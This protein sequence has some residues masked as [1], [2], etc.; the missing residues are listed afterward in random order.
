VNVIGLCFAV[1]AAVMGFSAGG[2]EE[3][4][5]PGFRL[6]MSRRSLLLAATACT[7]VALSVSAVGIVRDARRVEQAVGSSPPRTL[8]GQY[9]PIRAAECR[10][11]ESYLWGNWDPLRHVWAYALSPGGGAPY[12]FTRHRYAPVWYRVERIQPHPFEGLVLSDEDALSPASCVRRNRER[13][14]GALTWPGYDGVILA[15]SPDAIRAALSS[16]DVTSKERL[17]PGIWRLAPENRAI[18]DF[19]NPAAYH[20]ERGGFGLEE[21]R[22]GR[23]VAWSAGSA[24]WLDLD[25]AADP[26]S[27]YRLRLIA[28][29]VETALPQVVR[30]EINGK[31]VAELV[32]AT[33]AW[34]DDKV[35]IPAG[36]LRAGRNRF[37]FAYARL[38]GAADSRASPSGEGATAMLFDRLEVAQ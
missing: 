12:L 29:P 8:S 28:R 34:R 5:R 24:S 27:A 18:V 26:A 23:A 35:A 10:D 3:T 37:R 25:L 7:T 33:A 38:A 13:V 14:E 9:F 36:V 11:I 17:A 15:G 32:Y 21:R 31:Q 20:T 6:G 22:E 4:R 16:S 2:S 1:V 19:G 30:I